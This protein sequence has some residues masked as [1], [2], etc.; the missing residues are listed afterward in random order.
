ML[1]IVRA[2]MKN[3]WANSLLPAY[4]NIDIIYFFIVEQGDGIVMAL[5]VCKHL[6][7]LEP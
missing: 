3:Y 4:E 7:K 6:S 5:V 1:S 2:D